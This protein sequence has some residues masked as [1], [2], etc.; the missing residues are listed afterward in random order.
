MLADRRLL[1]MLQEGGQVVDQ[2]SFE[3][4]MDMLLDDE[5]AKEIEEGEFVRAPPVVRRPPVKTPHAKSFMPTSAKR[6]ASA[7]ATEE[8]AENKSKKAKKAKS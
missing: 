5:E 3:D 6:L 2:K 1:G 8:P 4:D 7:T